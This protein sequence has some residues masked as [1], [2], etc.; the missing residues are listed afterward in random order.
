MMVAASIAEWNII[1]AMDTVN[2]CASDNINCLMSPLQLLFKHDVK[3]AVAA[4]KAMD[5]VIRDEYQATILEAIVTK[6][7]EICIKTTPVTGEPDFTKLAEYINVPKVLMDKCV[8]GVVV[9]SSSGGW[10]KEKIQNIARVSSF[11]QVQ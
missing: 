10:G 2:R 11:I 3:G 9:K 5:G 4:V 6:A 8:R 1:D 7:A